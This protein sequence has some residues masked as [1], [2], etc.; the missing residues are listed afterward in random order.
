MKKVLNVGGGSKG[1]SLPPQYIDYEHLLLD[2]DPRGSPDIVCDARKLSSLDKAQFDAIYC[3]H[4]LEHYYRHDV[5]V[6]LAGFLHIL[7]EGG[8][9]H[10][11]VPD[12]HEVIQTAL[13]RDLDIED[14]L[15]N[16]AVG[17][18]TVLDVLYGLGTEIEESGQ[19]FY[20]HKTGFT[21]KSLL[22]A[23]REAGFSHSHIE[24]GNLEIN[25]LAFKG[26]PDQTTLALFGITS[27][28]PLTEEAPGTSAKFDTSGLE[29]LANRES[30]AGSLINKKYEDWINQRCFLKTDTK[31][32]D[33]KSYD[34]RESQP[35]FHLI[36]RLSAGFE[37]LLADTLDSLREQI[38][39]RWYLDI[40]STL[41]S[42]D[43]LEDVPN[44]G[45]HTLS[46]HEDFKKT[47]DF[48]AEANPCNWLI[49]IPA[50]ARPDIL[51][52]WR[53]AKEIS[54]SPN[55]RALF[56]DDDCCDNSGKRHSPRFKPGTN[57]S[58]LQATDMAG[59]LCV[60]KETWL[61]SGGAGES[62]G[63]P[64]FSQ[65]LR[66]A[67]KFGWQ[68][69]KHIPDVLITYL[70]AFP[71][72]MSSCQLALL[73]AMQKN[74][75]EGEISAVT[76]RSWNIRHALNN[77]PPVTIAILSQGQLELIIR[78]L[79]SV[80]KFTQ[81]PQY[82]IL[83][84]TDEVADDPGL[85]QWLKDIEEVSQSPKIRSLRIQGR[86]NHAARCNS[87]VAASENNLILLLRE[88]AVIVQDRWLE[89]LVR[90][91]QPGD[92]AATS[93]LLHNPGDAKILASGKTLGL[94]GVIESPYGGGKASLGE[95]GYLDCLQVTREASALS[96]SCLLIRKTAYQEAG[97]MDDIEL[98]DHLAD[99][100]LCLKMRKNNGRLIVQPRASVVFGGET[101]PYDIKLQLKDMVKKKDAQDSLHQRWGKTAFVDP[102]WNPNL[103]LC[104][105]T[106]LPETAYRAQWQYLPS[107]KPRILAHPIGNGQG[108]FRITS[109]LAA[110]RK[111]GLATECVWRQKV[112][113]MVRFFSTAEL[114][115]MEPS[116]FIIQNYIHDI[117]LMALD[118]WNSSN[119]RPFIVYALDDLIDDMDKTNPFRKHF[120]P[121]S[122]SRLKYALARCDRLV[123]S[124]DFLAESYQ[125]F[126]PDIRVVP[127][128]LEQDIWRPLHSLKRTGKKPRIGWAGGTTH[129][130]DLIFL[131][132]IIE[133][134]R[135]EA[136]WIFFGMCPD[137]IR[138]LLAE[139]HEIVPFT[140]YP[141]YL[142]SL[143]LDI[144]VAP[145]AQTPFNQGKSNLR[146]LEYGALGIPVVCTDIDPYQNSPACRVANTV[147]AWT[148]AL[149]E[150][151]YDA[152]ARECEGIAM[153]EW[154]H[155]NYMLEEHLEEWLK[156]HLPT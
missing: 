23:L 98:G 94:M 87:A 76:A 19:D 16:S 93:P 152:E 138:P 123:V 101:N 141:A 61:A 90:T 128:R 89:E 52:L 134:T 14:T 151:I 97:G 126:I 58:Y 77:P 113:N 67:E 109:P 51:Y 63:S 83:I 43:G 156:A 38:D 153:R 154:V 7:T 10:I 118:E 32:L 136:D 36:I 144:A 29:F 66:V 70:N 78:C 80:I 104:D 132:E 130:G 116:T 12:I 1:I 3:S 120:P 139:Y 9:A 28:T 5:R 8:F 81:Y 69:I 125:H 142:A 44:I 91:S 74:G 137:E 68:T 47:V 18:I 84:V 115:R 146:L 35:F 127:N 111:A 65:M 150:R 88:E 11:R 62:N 15:Y 31:F 108:D 82:E 27:A 13:D 55:A 129:Q 99:T 54:L 135:D 119:C 6:V 140:E 39:E 21:E 110:I 53:L 102:F 49:E 48:L 107:D 56:V 155:R 46:S 50:G 45:W 148:T 145:L 71:S 133:Q 75:V 147:K 86:T 121:N 95:N 124:T 20:A 24:V 114:A 106:P 4:N 57:S 96:S 33:H 73:N 112:V 105:T 26:E 103:S 40:I 2:I 92:V 149:R 64:W 30:K 143:N 100:D 34:T 60:S 79:D 17:P 25:A 72:D 22:N 117:S 41:P 122:R 42:P 85:S 59:P 37:T 131:K